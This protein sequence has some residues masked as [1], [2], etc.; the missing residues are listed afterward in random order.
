MNRSADMMIAGQGVYVFDALPSTNDE[1]AR[2]ARAGV[3]DGSMVWA[4]QQTAGRGRR[5]R[6]WVSQP[7]NL[8]VSFILRPPV[9]PARAAELTFVASL[10]LAETLTGLAG[11]GRTVACKWP[12][13]VLL[14]GAKV[15]GILLESDID[16]NGGVA[17]VVAGIGVNLA[18]RPDD[19]ERPAAALAAADVPAPSP[20][21]ALTALAGRFFPLYRQWV[22]GGFPAI[23]DAWLARAAGIGQPIAVRLPHETL[24]G[25]FH[26]LDSDG[27]LLLDEGGARPPRRIAAG[28]VFFAGEATS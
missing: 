13:D 7:G 24:N 8:F 5:G 4:L 23:R 18:N 28:D 9:P 27:V 22:A 11:P 17:W 1:A 14:D 2:L 19:V 6:A 25:V 3:P 16:G 26:G 20:E 15:A 21:T 12:N 10:A